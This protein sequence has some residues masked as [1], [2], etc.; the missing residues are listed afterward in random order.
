MA[1]AIRGARSRTHSLVLDG[2]GLTHIDSAGIEMLRETSR[3]L[4]ADG[5]TRVT[6]RLRTRTEE[7]APAGSGR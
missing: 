1:E 6:A 4:R 7:Q 2:E 5:I 3:A